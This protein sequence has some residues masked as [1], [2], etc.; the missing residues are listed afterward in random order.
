MDLD[1]STGLQRGICDAYGHMLV[2]GGR[3][4]IIVEP[5]L[6]IWDK[7]APSLIVTEAGGRYTA[8]DGG[9]PLSGE[10]ALCDE[11]RTIL[12]SKNYRLRVEMMRR[13][14]KLTDGG[15]DGCR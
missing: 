15:A 8:M 5:E 3:A 1:R 6:S 13:M 7:A 11:W 14:T 2:A 12:S 10:G 9:N 4:E